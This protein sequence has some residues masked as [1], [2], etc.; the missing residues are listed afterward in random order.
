MNV[1]PTP[2][3]RWCIVGCEAS[4]REQSR[5]RSRAVSVPFAPRQHKKEPILRL[6]AGILH[7]H[8]NL[9]KLSTDHS[10]S[11]AISPTPALVSISSTQSYVCPSPAAS[12]RPWVPQRPAPSRPTN[13]R[14]HLPRV[15]PL[16]S[17]P[18]SSPSSRMDSNRLLGSLGTPRR[19]SSKQ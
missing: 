6:G 7:Q 5:R 11:L 16:S 9:C 10:D 3:S 4:P 12:R 13:R 17:T 14:A 8:H 19:L 15:S 2:R 18:T 1:T